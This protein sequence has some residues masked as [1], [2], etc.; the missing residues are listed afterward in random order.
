M[1]GAGGAGVNVRPAPAA[2]TQFHQ[3][4]GGRRWPI[5]SAPDIGAEAAARAAQEAGTGTSAGPAP[6]H[7]PEQVTRAEVSERGGDAGS[8]HV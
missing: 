1:G 6:P 4:L 3:K 2:L 5:A 7:S 8:E